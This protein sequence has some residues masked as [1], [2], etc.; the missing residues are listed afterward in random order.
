MSCT[1]CDHKNQDGRRFC[2]QCGEN[3][4]V[5]RHECAQCG[6]PNDDDD[7]FCGSCGTAIAQPMDAASRRP[8][9]YSGISELRRG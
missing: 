3:L 9:V 2:G 6:F 7:R 1:A 5:E 4:F 8:P